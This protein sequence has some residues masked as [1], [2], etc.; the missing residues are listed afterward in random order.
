[1]SALLVL[2]VCLATWRLAR[3]VT[4]DYLAEPIRV[5]ADT[6]GERVGYL[7]SCPWCMSIWLAPLVAAPAV[8]W[9]TNRVVWL[10]LLW[11][12]ASA[13]AGMLSSIEDALDPDGNE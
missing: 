3:F 10:I 6:I 8:W 11:L 9:P 4:V 1:M 5:R 7:F 12:S 13:V 2:L